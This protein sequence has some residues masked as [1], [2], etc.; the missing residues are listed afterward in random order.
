MVT[1]SLADY[2]FTTSEVANRNLVRQ[3]ASLMNDGMSEEKLLNDENG[4]LPE[5]KYA[6]ERVPQKVWH[7][8]NV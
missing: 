4:F 7:V 6:Y 3:G 1:D 8:G 5:D 2:M